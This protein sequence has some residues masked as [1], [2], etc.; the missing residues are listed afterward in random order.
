MC[1]IKMY[2]L[3]LGDSGSG[4]TAMIQNMLGRLQKPGG[5]QIKLGTILGDIFFYS[6]TKKARLLI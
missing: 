4:K 2:L 1:K 6:E 5:L 3:I